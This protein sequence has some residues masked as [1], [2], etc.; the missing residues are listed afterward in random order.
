MEYS[1]IVFFLCGHLKNH[2]VPFFTIYPL[3]WI[4]INFLHLVNYQFYIRLFHPLISPTKVRKTVGKTGGNVATAQTG[5]K[6]AIQILS[7]SSYCLSFFL[8][9]SMPSLSR[10]DK[11]SDLCIN[12]RLISV[13]FTTALPW[14]ASETVP[15]RRLTKKV[16]FV[17]VSSTRCNGDSYVPKNKFRH[18]DV[19]IL[20]QVTEQKYSEFMGLLPPSP[21]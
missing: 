6:D 19:Y 12:H 14:L 13:L 4:W 20:I 11:H 18:T 3:R 9:S 1:V 5:R 8:L 7:T 21:E 16:I 2:R 15:C 17:R 10:N